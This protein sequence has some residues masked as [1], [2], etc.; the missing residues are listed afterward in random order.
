MRHQKLSVWLNGKYC[1]IMVAGQAMIVCVM[2]KLSAYTM[3]VELYCATKCSGSTIS[4]WVWSQPDSRISW[5]RTEIVWENG[6]ATDCLDSG[7][8]SAAS[9]AVLIWLNAFHSQI[10]GVSDRVVCTWVNAATEITK[11]RAK[12]SAASSVT[13]GMSG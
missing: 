9:S 11:V 10:L 12:I 6:T 4:G 13:E 8:S 7:V 3:V 5:F 1:I 2:L